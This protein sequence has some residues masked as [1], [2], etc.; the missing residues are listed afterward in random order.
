VYSQV[1]AATGNPIAAHAA[2]VAAQKAMVIPVKALE[3]AFGCIAGEVIEKIKGIVSDI[4]T[5]TVNNVE[6]FVSCAADQFVGTLLNSIIGVLETLFSGPL[7]AVSKLLQFFSNF[8][9]G[10]LLREAIGILSEVGVGFACNQNVND[11]KGLVN[12]WT[13]GGGPSGSR[14]T[15]LPSMVDSY[16]AVKDITN[17]VNSGVENLN[18]VQECFTSALKFA[19]PPVIN[20]FGGGPGSGAK[21]IP[22]FGNL[23][24]NSNGNTTASVIGVQLTNPGSGYTYPPF[25]EIIDDNDQG[26]GAIA[27]AIINEVGEVKSIYIVSEGENYSIGNVEEY[28]VL[29]VFI[30][31]G[32]SNY[33]DATVADNLGNTYNTQIVD[34]RIYQVT[35]LNNVDSLPVLTVTSNTGSGAI[36]RP[37]LGA[38][39]FKGELQTS[40][41]C[42]V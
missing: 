39:K 7:D 15:L 37:L 28:S 26:Y 6:R 5:S 1:L 12:E 20:I 10:N 31:N 2:G 25:V 4:L 18:S 13:I 22:I 40:I 17:I 38:A 42:P 32:G 8:S 23:V 36:L 27:R 30:E 24:T 33:K 9:V 21:A 34:G 14:S 29:N 41:D 35:P 11:F 16:L 3:E 19:S